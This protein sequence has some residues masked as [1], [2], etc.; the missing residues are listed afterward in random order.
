MEKK[1]S[2]NLRNMLLLFSLLPILI[3]V[4]GT[5]LFSAIKT[6][7]ELEAQT[8]ETLKTACTGLRQ[9]YEKIYNEAGAIEY[10]TTYVDS[11]KDYG[12]EQTLFMG[13]TRFFTSIK[14]N[15]GAR[16]EGTKA[17]DA[18]INQCLKGGSDYYSDSVTIN[19]K[20]YYVYYEP[21]YG[22]DGAIFGMA[23]AGKT[24]ENVNSTISSLVW[25]LVI[26]AAVI[27]AIFAVIVLILAKKVADPLMAVAE[28]VSAVASGDLN[29]PVNVKSSVKESNQLITSTSKLQTNLANIIGQTKTTAGSLMGNAGTVSSLAEQSN[30]SAEQISFAMEDL[31]QGATSMAQ[32]V[33]NINE[34]VIEMGYAINDISENAEHLSESSKNIKEANDNASEYIKKVSASSEKSVE[35][36]HGI[37]KQ[38]A[39]TNNSVKKIEEAVDMISSIAGQTNLLALNASI[40]AARAGE[41]G[42]GFAVV[43]T[44]IK[45]LSEQ[46]NDMAEQIKQ[47]VGNITAQSEASVQ[48]SSD[49]AEIISSEQNYIK[50]TREKFDVLNVEIEGSLNGINAIASK[51][52]TLDSVK[53]TIIGSVQ[54]LS[55]ISEENA[56]SSQEVSASV[57]NIADAIRD[58]ANNSKDMNEMAES[59]NA[60]VSFFK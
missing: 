44:E 48:L 42:K 14:D 9:Y 30:S 57:S 27:F 6:T 59:L 56:A 36:V 34:Q 11:M 19:N 33:Q 22:P 12:V 26:I 18:V 55:A 10:D 51:V 47:I 24:C 23:F 28:G 16:I 7:D 35:A 8:K 54:D 21:M 60:A 46:S 32:N 25:T 43:A 15:S 13:D 37:S 52:S 2:F 45:S 29:K 4:I 49:V 1:S 38:I 40:E 20:L 39:E 53:N 5:T 50:E 41:A 17:S 31:A 3:A 58:I